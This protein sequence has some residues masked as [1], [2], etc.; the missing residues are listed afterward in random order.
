M[1]INKLFPFQACAEHHV[2]GLNC[3]Y[4][5]RSCQNWRARA[6][7]AFKTLLVCC[8]CA[9]LVSCSQQTQD[10]DTASITAMLEESEASTEVCASEGPVSYLCGLQNAEDILRLGN[11][12]WLLASG[13]NGSL[14]GDTSV[15][16]KIHL[17]NH[18]TREW[19]VLLPADKITIA[20]DTVMF[21]ECPGPIDTTN[22]SA[23]GLALQTLD[24]GPQRYR[25]YMTSHGAREAIEVFEVDALVKPTLTWVGCVPMPASS[26]T[27]SLAILAD[28]GFFAT[29]FMDP[30][31]EGMTGVR[32]GEVTGHVFEWHP[33]SGLTVLPGTE[34]SGANG[35]VISDDERW[36]YVAAFG[37]HEV[38]R[39]DRSSSPVGKETVS[40][41]IA[42]D[43]IRWSDDGTLYTAGEN[44][45]S[46]CEQGT[47]Q[48]GWSILE[49]VPYNLKATLVAA[50]DHEASLQ[51][52][53]SALLVDDEIWVGTYSGD[54]VAIMAKP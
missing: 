7:G 21:K 29:Q 18:E 16:G 6:A 31:A 25:L 41:A 39:F 40:V 45:D 24:T 30:L 9:V 26:W 5:Q 49:I 53:S 28:G 54:R 32:A 23:H 15:N 27:N 36:I 34:L 51:A 14:T 43:N 22:F 48:G 42:P 13:M 10:N 2:A 50:I 52:A 19:E 17:I 46:S 38:V 1:R 33:G 8:V 3:F 11:S 47:C 20:A 37:T 44:V 12:Q 4:P 35:I